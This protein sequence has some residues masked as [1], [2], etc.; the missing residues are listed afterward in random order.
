MQ[1]ASGANQQVELLVACWTVVEHQEVVGW[2]GLPDAVHLWVLSTLTA[3]RI[4]AT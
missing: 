3:I 4:Y 1:F 2:D